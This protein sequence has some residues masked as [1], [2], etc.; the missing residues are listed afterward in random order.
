MISSQA[1]PTLA[2][3]LRAECEEY[4]K[5]Q[6]LLEEEHA[7]LSNVQ[8]ERV[9]LITTEKQALY[10]RLQ[11][12][13]RRRDACL[14]ADGIAAAPGAIKTWTERH[15]EH[16]QSV[17][18]EWKRLTQLVRKTRRQNTLN[19]RIA[20]ALVQHFHSRLNLLAG[21]QGNSAATTYGRDGNP[22]VSLRPPGSIAQI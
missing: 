15:P 18:A 13:S 8:A 22:S 20:S 17:V 2:D 6:S 14:A 4:G 16:A 1:A 9:A 12:L 21:S 10:G 7:A 11:A 3:Q 5:L 19:G